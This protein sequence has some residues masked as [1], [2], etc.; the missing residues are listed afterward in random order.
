[1]RALIALAV[2]LVACSAAPSSEEVNQKPPQNQTGSNTP[3]PSGT[4][5]PT[6]NN[7]PAASSK[8]LTALQ[9]KKAETL[10]SI[11]ENSS[12]VLQY[13]YCED[14]DDGRGYTSGRAGF[15]S[16]T[17]DAVLV[18]R[19][20]VKKDPNSRLAKY[21]P[22]L[23]ALE[24]KFLE[25]FEAQASTATL[26]NVGDYCDDWSKS[27]G[28]AFRACQD[29]VV[30]TVY[31][32]PAIAE[33][34]KHGMT[35]ALTIAELYDASINHGID[36]VQALIAKIPATKTTEPEW[37]HEF[38]VLR[39]KKLQADPTWAEAVDRIATY[40]KLLRAGNLDLSA[41]IVTDA[42]A[43]ELFPEV[44]GLKDSGYPK[45]TIA[46]NGDASCK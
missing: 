34:K 41:E 32:E 13:G 33:A 23:T 44:T 31:F 21:V 45:C 7:P 39:L 1:M 15:C 38:L 4:T 12:P 24:K 14:I 18:V 43:S 8:E 16:G 17:A 3:S 10:T 2:V 40:E 37:L 22:A 36:E 9:R 19:C 25:N 42:K 35:S 11:W 28:D 27:E 29:E 20:L 26:D 46:S 5:T 30:N 6:P